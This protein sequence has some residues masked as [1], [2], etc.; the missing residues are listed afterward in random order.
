METVAFG[1][2]CV[3]FT[4]VFFICVQHPSTAFNMSAIHS[5]LSHAVSFSNALKKTT[6]TAP[7]VSTYLCCPR[8]F[9]SCTNAV[10]YFF[11]PARSFRTLQ[12]GESIQAHAGATLSFTLQ[13]LVN[14]VPMP[15]TAIAAAT[16]H[17]LPLHCATTC[18]RAFC[19]GSGA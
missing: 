14:L 18:L 8:R 4:L 6:T 12:Q 17:G 7:F 2:R 15:F 11:C 16:V 3:C 1:D 5:Q 9:A 19:C 13:L 10:A